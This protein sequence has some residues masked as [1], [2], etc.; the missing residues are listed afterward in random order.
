[1]SASWGDTTPLLSE[2]DSSLSSI[3]L[4]P[5]DVDLAWLNIVFS[6]MGYLVGDVTNQLT[7]TATYAQGICIHAHAREMA[8]RRQ[9]TKVNSATMT[10]QMSQSSVCETIEEEMMVGVGLELGS[11]A[12]SLSS[13]SSVSSTLNANTN[14][15]FMP[16][17]PSS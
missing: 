11:S 14:T 2:A 10:T 5:M 7:T 1:M 13:K 16:P 12:S 15:M 9:Y 4:D 17:F 3:D 8:H 6:V